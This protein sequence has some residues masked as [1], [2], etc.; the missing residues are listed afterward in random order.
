MTMYRPRTEKQ[1]TPLDVAYLTILIGTFAV[2]GVV[3]FLLDPDS[4]F[5][6][7]KNASLCIL[8]VALGSCGVIN[9]A[10]AGTYGKIWTR[11]G[12]VYK[13]ANPKLFGVNY[14]M[15]VIVLIAMVVTVVALLFFL[16]PL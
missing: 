4:W 3:M 9:L 15:N 16:P 2:T 12:P 1:T 13:A 14:G 11:V 10:I 5:H 6:Q 7:H 8:F